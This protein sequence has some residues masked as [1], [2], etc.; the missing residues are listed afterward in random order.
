MAAQCQGVNETK[1]R[2]SGNQSLKVQI[3]QENRPEWHAMTPVQSLPIASIP[4]FFIESYDQLSDII[5]SHVSA[6]I[7]GVRVTETAFKT[8]KNNLNFKRKH[9]RADDCTVSSDFSR[10]W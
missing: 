10:R 6:S 2:R 4:T 1:T 8:G 7:R 5:F 3:F 9:C